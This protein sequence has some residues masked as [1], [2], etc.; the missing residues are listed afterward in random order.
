M[1]YMFDGA[2]S[3]QRPSRFINS[4]RQNAYHWTGCVQ[5]HFV[6]WVCA[7]KMGK[8]MRSP[9]LKKKMPFVC[10]WTRACIWKMPKIRFHIWNM[11]MHVPR[12]N[13]AA[14]TSNTNCVK[15]LLFL[16]TI[17]LNVLVW[18]LSFTIVSTEIS[19]DRSMNCNS[20]VWG[21]SF[22]VVFVWEW[23]FEH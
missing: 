15:D 21:T 6:L 17:R 18:R 7:L 12:I 13:K 19:L 4:F 9:P 2:M 8:I 10:M 22:G 5:I 14:L 11:W 20:S 3:T 16:F 23:R 1:V